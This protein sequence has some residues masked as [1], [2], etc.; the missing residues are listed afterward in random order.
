M[1]YQIYYQKFLDIKDNK[2]ET[3]VK[4]SNFNRLLNIKDNNYKKYN[5]DINS[6]NNN[7]LKNNKIESFYKNQSKIGIVSPF[8]INILSVKGKDLFDIGYQAIPYSCFN[9]EYFKIINLNNNNYLFDIDNLSCIKN[10]YIESYY[11]NK[12]IKEDAW[13]IYNS[14]FEYFQVSESYKADYLLYINGKPSYKIKNLY[15]IVIYLDKNKNSRLIFKEFKTGFDYS[16]E[17]NSYCNANLKSIDNINDNE[18]SDLIEDIDNNSNNNNNDNENKSLLVN[19]KCVVIDDNENQ[20]IAVQKTSKAKNLNREL[21]IDSYSSD[22]TLKNLKIERYNNAID[23]YLNE[24]NNYNNLNNIK[25]NN[26]AT[27]NNKN[28]FCNKSKNIINTINIYNVKLKKKRKLIKPKETDELNKKVKNCP[29]CYELIT[30]E[31]SLDNCSHTYCLKCI[32]ELS[33]LDSKC[34]LCKKRYFILTYKDGN[35][36]IKEKIKKRNYSETIIDYIEEED[37]LQENSDAEDVDE[38]CLICKKSD[39]KN[40]LM[41]CDICNYNITHTYCDNLDKVPEGE[42]R[43]LLCR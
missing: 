21:S 6:N 11:N 9:I 16:N 10:N 13:L 37:Y 24:Y 42:W 27:K 8:D 36:T 41:I 29:I 14:N 28:K 1:L 20:D 7:L 25:Q 35:H 31:V 30:D 33:K 22:S 26:Y 34:P 17:Y 18:L 23:A 39:N 40:V 43:C 15:D 32:R 2:Q 5:L 19:K 3:Y 4:K 38:T 12:N